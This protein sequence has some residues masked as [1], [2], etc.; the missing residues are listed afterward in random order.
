MIIL[1]LKSNHI[2]HG[3]QGVI[4]HLRPCKK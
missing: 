4:L 3:C 2:V 1:Y